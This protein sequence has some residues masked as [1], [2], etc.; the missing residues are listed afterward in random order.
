MY[1]RQIL[2]L[3]L[4]DESVLAL[5]HATADER[6]ALDSYRRFIQMYGK[7]VLG[8]PGEEFER[9]F[10]GARD[11]AGAE[12]DHDVPADLL[13]LVIDRFKAIV[14][15]HTGAPF[16]Q[17]PITQLHGA[18]DAVFASWQSPRAVTYRL[19]LIHI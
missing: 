13:H 2:N 8:V 1:K 11:L 3:G 7:V 9:R 14:E 15:E 12:T 19:S 6:F 17:D 5:A 10:E 4:N 18:I 16:P